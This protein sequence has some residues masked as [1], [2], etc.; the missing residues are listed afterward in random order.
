MEIAEE[1]F[2]GVVAKAWCFGRKI[3]IDKEALMPVD[4]TVS[5]FETEVLGSDLPVLVDF[6]ASWCGPCRILYPIVEEIAQEYAGQ[7]KV[8]KV[9]VDEQPDLALKFK[10]MSI[11]TLILFKGGEA[12]STSI[13]VKPKQSIVEMFA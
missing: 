1:R 11:P 7:V 10:V 13:G 12:V 6:W 5:N 3:W 4:V 8:G 9:N 2:C